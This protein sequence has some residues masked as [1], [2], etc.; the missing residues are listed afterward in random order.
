MVIILFLFLLSV[1]FIFENVLGL[2][3]NKHFE[4]I[5]EART[6]RQQK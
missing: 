5:E 2:Y 6:K 3:W 1:P 4:T